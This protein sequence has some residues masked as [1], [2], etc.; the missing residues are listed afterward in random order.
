[1]SARRRFEE[2]RRKVRELDAV[3]LALMMRGEDW[4]PKQPRSNSLSDPTAAAAIR[5]V[6]EWAIEEAELIRRREQL[7]HYIGESLAI[8]QGVRDGLGD[9]YADVIEQRYVDGLAWC[10]IESHGEH[11]PKSTGCRYLAI[12]FDW[13]DAIGISRCLRGEYE[14]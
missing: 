6:D 9:T 7:E 3:N 12:A 10:D 13:L 11:V 5:N 1:M 8:I 2:T 14:I 4:K